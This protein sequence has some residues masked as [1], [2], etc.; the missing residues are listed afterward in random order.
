MMMIRADDNEGRIDEMTRQ[1]ILYSTY[2][3]LT[4]DLRMC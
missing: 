4:S 1:N 3:W 2:S